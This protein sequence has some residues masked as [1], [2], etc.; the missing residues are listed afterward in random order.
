MILADI[1]SYLS[2]HRRAALI[3]LA[4][5]F[6]A[7]P[8][9][10]RGMLGALERKGRVRRIATTTCSSGCTKCDQA[11]PEIYEWL[12]VTNQDLNGPRSV[13]E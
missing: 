4:H 2:Q 10:L 6:G 9:A 1:T 12:G 13:H 7:S 3:D 11:S 8:D 5:R